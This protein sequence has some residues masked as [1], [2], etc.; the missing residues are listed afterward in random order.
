M[1]KTLTHHSRVLDEIHKIREEITNELK[2]KTPKEVAAYWSQKD[3]PS[4][5][6]GVKKR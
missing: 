6:K 2:G 3:E 1:S 5:Y 4:S